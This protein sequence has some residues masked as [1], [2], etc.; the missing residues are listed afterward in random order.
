MDFSFFVILRRQVPYF[1]FQLSSDTIIFTNVQL[2]KKVEISA[3]Y[4]VKF[5]QDKLTKTKCLNYSIKNLT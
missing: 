2:T 3:G 5:L 1:R 4:I